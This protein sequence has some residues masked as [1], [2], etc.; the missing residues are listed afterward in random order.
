MK[1]DNSLLLI[2]AG[3]HARA[4][5]DVIEHQG[6]YR[7]VGIIGREVEVGSM[8]LGHAVLGTD[9]N[10]AELSKGCSN[11]IVTVGQIKS[12]DLRLRLYDMLKKESVN[13]PIVV[14]P[15]AYV[16]PY[17]IIGEGS[18]VMHGAILNAGA[19]VGANCIINSNALVE[20]DAKIDDHCH[21][22]TNVVINGGVYVGKGSFI[23]SGCII[24]E[25]VNIGDRCIIGMGQRIVK[26]C[27][28]GT[29]LF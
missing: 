14:S 18:I 11:A 26:D 7:I 2:G 17:A 19:V 25:G 1:A 12:V 16:S 23:G 4:C 10:F 15:R 5:I 9:F 24:R 28:D 21:I 29:L 8:V 27:T 6:Y 20:H 13:L 3:G 22:S